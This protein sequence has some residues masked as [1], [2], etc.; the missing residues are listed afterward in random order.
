MVIGAL[1]GAGITFWSQRLQREDAERD[2]HRNNQR[3]IDWKAQDFVIEVQAFAF[4]SMLMR[5]SPFADSKTN[6]EYVFDYPKSTVLNARA[7][8]FEARVK[9]PELKSHIQGL[10]TELLLANKH[11]SV[12]KDNKGTMHYHCQKFYYRVAELY[13]E[14]RKQEQPAHPDYF[15]LD[16]GPPE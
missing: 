4:N 1:L 10:N 15:K 11:G 2:W 5:P 3:D 13:G 8:A 9:D 6:F 12:G 16:V 7:N 14:P